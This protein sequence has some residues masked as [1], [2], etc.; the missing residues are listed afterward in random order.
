[1]AQDTLNRRVQKN[2]NALQWV[3]KL[4]LTNYPFFDLGSTEGLASYFIDWLKHPSY[5]EYWRRWSIEDYYSK[6]MVPAYHVGGW[7]D[8]F[9]GGTVRNYVG[10]KAAGGSDEARRGQRLLIG[11]WYHGPFNGKSGEM[12]FSPQAKGDTDTG[13]SERSQSRFLSWAKTLGARKTVGRW[14]EPAARVTSCT[15]E[16]MHTPCLVAETSGRPSHKMKVQ[17]LSFTTRQNLC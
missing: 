9:M 3:W 17:T 11:P 6:V 10:L 16:E 14:L 8:I 2:S 5:D 12:D 4:P 15:L 1:M 13:R 7:Y